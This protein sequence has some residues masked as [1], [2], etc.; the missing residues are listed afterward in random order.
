MPDT[1]PVAPPLD[2]SPPAR[3]A[4]SA[5][6]GYLGLALSGWGLS[7]VLGVTPHEDLLVGAGLA[8]FGL[9]LLATAPR[10]PRMPR[11][12]AW[13]VAGGGVALA[14]G[15]AAY[16]SF[17]HTGWD[18][19]KAAIVASGLALACSAPFLDRPLGKNRRRGAGQ[20]VGT[21]VGCGLLVVGAPLAVWG[22]QAAFKSAVGATPTEAFVHYALLLPLGALLALAGL[23]PS[24]EGQTVTY[25]TLKGPLS[26]E[27]GAAC[28]GVQ[29]MAI[30]AG[31]LA[32][33]LLTER[34]G[35]R[36][37][38]VWSAIGLGG[39]Y[40]AN[41]LRLVMLF[42]VGYAWGPE[43]LVRVHAEAGWMFFVAWALLFAWLA[44]GKGNHVRR[45]SDGA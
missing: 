32:V 35:G 43:A 4:M 2:S 36:R 22:I 30:F 17:A 7:I 29:A 19:P 6:R 34:P 20:T 25:A 5:R 42:A 16:T 44:R 33:F 40:V 41:L 26:L 21:L 31:V 39:V 23:H 9:A 14:A 18:V 15:V 28:S 1:A 24:V 45:P 37:L 11:L 13:L 8:I 27:V 3:Q 38:A 10:L 12:P